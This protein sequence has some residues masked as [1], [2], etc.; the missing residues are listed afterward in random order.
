MTLVSK[1]YRLVSIKYG[2]KITKITKVEILK[3]QYLTN[4]ISTKQNYF[5][6]SAKY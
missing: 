5:S 1:M 4:I 2:L 6:V 3:N